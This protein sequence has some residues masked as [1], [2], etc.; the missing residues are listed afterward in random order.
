MKVDWEGLRIIKP[1]FLGKRVMKEYDLK[2]LVDYID[3][4]PFFQTW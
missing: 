4:D 1:T 2:S 3:W